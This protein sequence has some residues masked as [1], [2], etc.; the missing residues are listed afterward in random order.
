MAIYTIYKIDG[1]GM[2]V[3]EGEYIINDYVVYSL[4][5]DYYKMLR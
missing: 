5:F 4:I 2:E 3:I 1:K